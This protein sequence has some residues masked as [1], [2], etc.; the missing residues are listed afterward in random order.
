MPARGTTGTAGSVAEG[1]AQQQMRCVHSIVQVRART[2]RGRVPASI[3]RR[4]SVLACLHALIGCTLTGPFYTCSL[5]IHPGA[6]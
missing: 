3:V 1:S 4:H 2:W 6:G 5:Q